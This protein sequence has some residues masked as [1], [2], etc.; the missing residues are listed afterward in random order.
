MRAG[1]PVITMGHALPR[2]PRARSG[3]Y[4][5]DDAQCPAQWAQHDALA[6]GSESVGQGRD[7]DLVRDHDQ[8][9]GSGPLQQQRARLRGLTRRVVPVLKNELKADSAA[10]RPG[11]A[12]SAVSSVR[13]HWDASTL[14]TATPC[15]RRRAPIRRACAR[16]TVSRLRWLLQS[17]SRNA[18]GS[19]TPGALAWRN[20][21]MP[22]ARRA[23]HTA[24]SLASAGALAAW[25][26]GNVHTGSS[27]AARRAARRVGCGKEG[28]SMAL[29]FAEW[30]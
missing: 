2:W 19:P 13:H 4:A 3:L 8:C 21:T 11:K 10:T 20:S 9:T 17:P 14:P 28:R 18:C 23:S 25:A 22:P 15:S 16:P 1:R 7:V 29:V 5:T 12:S 30:W 24:A 6:G 27:R 26:G